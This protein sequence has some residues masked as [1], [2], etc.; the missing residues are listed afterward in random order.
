MNDIFESWIYGNE[1]AWAIYCVIIAG[2][3]LNVNRISVLAGF[4]YNATKRILKRME[5]DKWVY[6]EIV[7]I[8]SKR[9]VNVYYSSSKQYI[10]NEKAVEELISKPRKLSRSE[11]AFNTVFN[12]YVDRAKKKGVDFYLTKFEFKELVIK[13]CHY[14]GVPYSVGLKTA[15]PHN[16]LDR[17]DSKKGYTHDNVVPCCF[18]CNRMKWDLS[19]E[20]WLDQLRKIIHYKCEES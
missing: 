17:I 1:K 3:G 4:E 13:P 20:E 15:F 9:K 11:R 10:A 14:C 8:G 12:N 2:N 18:I 5:A 7:T 19:K 16:T 6:K